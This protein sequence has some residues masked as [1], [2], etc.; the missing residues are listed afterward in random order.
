MRPAAPRIKNDARQ[1]DRSAIHALNE[2]PTDTP[3]NWLV[4]KIA[5]ARER[6]RGEC[7]AAIRPYA[8]GMKNDSETPSSARHTSRTTPFGDIPESVCEGQSQHRNRWHL[9]GGRRAASLPS[10][11]HAVRHAGASNDL[12]VVDAQRRARDADN[13]AAIAEDAAR[14]ARIDLLAG[15]G[16]FP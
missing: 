14:Q 10:L 3:A 11:R 15:A 7:A 4:P 16:R 12:D 5:I 9:D 13:A 8:A 1:L 6:V 2:P